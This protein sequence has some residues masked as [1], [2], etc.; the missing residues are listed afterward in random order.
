[1]HTTFSALNRVAYIDTLS[2]E[3]FDLLVI[4][5]G[6]TGAGIALDATSRGMKVA[7]IEQLDFAS[8]TSSRSTKLIHGGL[9]YLK[10]LEIALVHETGTERAIL[11]KNAPHIVSPEN[12]LLPIIE[13]G[14]LGKFS[15]SMGLW[16]YDYLAGVKEGERRKMLNK[17]ETL[18]AEPLLRNDIVL[19]GGLYKEYRTDDARLTIEVLKTAVQH[20]VTALNYVKATEFQYEQN[21]ITAV[22]AEDIFSKKQFTIKA[23]KIVNAAGPWVDTLRKEDQ[24]LKGKSLHLTKGVHLVVPYSKLTLKQAVYFDVKDGRMIFAI[25]RGKVTYIGTTDTNYKGATETPTTTQEDVAYILSAVNFMF[26]TI[27]L[28]VEDIISTWAGLRPL[29]HEDG[30]SPSELSRKDEIFFSPSGLISIAGGKLTGFRKMAERVTNVVAK[31]LQKENGK[32]YKPCATAAMILS[33]GNIPGINAEAI[34]NY[35]H[36][37][38]GEATQIQITLNQ[39]VELVNKYGTATEKII[40]RAYELTATIP[41]ADKRILVAELDYAIEHEMVT[42][43][44]D[45][46]VRRT[47]RLYFERNYILSVYQLL[48]DYMAQRFNWSATQQTEQDA[49]FKKEYDL[50][51]QFAN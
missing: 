17:E 4:G 18:N 27:K 13:K 39:V 3:T 20:G 28:K 33:G 46:L 37:L 36:K 9:R 47:G 2:S 10:Q 12:M 49:A 48:K 31:Q 50:V 42:N 29:I 34:S 5:G 23:A 11:H 38:A 1:L 6:I 21:K 32:T 41:D 25:P 40:E 24:S 16:V 14:S 8:G 30:K 45:F 19:G 35:K 22:V 44:N 15:T 51:M 43:L 26:P 7:L